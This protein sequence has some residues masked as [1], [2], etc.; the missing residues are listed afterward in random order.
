MG[1]AVEVMKRVLLLLTILVPL[2]SSAQ[3]M[4]T[5]SG[6]YTYYAPLN[7]TVEQ[8]KATAVERA[9]IKIIADHFGT[10]VGVN[11]STTVSNINGDT[12]VSFLSIGESEVKG[13]W[14]GTSGEPEIDIR[15]ED[16]LLV[17]HVRIKGTIREIT[18]AR[19]PIETALLRNG[20]EDKY[21]SDIFRNG[22]Y[23]YMSFASPIDGYVTAYLYD[24][25]GVSRLLPLKNQT[26]GSQYVA[27]GQRYV[28]FSKKRSQYSVQLNRQVETE[29][30]EYTIYCDEDNE[31]NRIYVIFSPNE[32][33]RPLDNTATGNDMPAALSF[34]DF[35]SWL[36]K[37]RKQDKD[38]CV[39]IKDI[40]IRK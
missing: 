32:F 28:F 12:S 4:L 19:I 15:Y 17:V 7:V 18:S 8:A 6:E 31:I 39:K 26:R 38:M 10:V 22:D 25:S 34:E 24:R 2:I 27:G 37:C 29:Y 21:E 13:E 9:K 30:S 20:T 1:T 40:M 16:N 5:T 23:M 14:I 35:Q 36:V 11:N 3:K 33:T